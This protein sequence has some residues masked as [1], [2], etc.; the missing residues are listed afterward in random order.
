MK[1]RFFARLLPLWLLIGLTSCQVITPRTYQLE[2]IH[3]TYTK[4][5]VAAPVPRAGQSPPVGKGKGAFNATLQSI[6]NYEAQFGKGTREAAHLTVLEGMIY[7]QSGAPGMARL[8]EP[9]VA[10]AK[11]RLMSSGGVAT[12][13][14]IFAD[15]FPELV[16][17][18]SAV[19]GVNNGDR[20]V[21]ASDFRAAADGIRDKLAKITPA[22]RAAAQE[23]S[24][25]AYV[26]TS[27]AIFYIWAASGGSPPLSEM[28]RAGRDLLDPWLTPTERSSAISGSYKRS[29]MEWG[30][31]Q[32][33]V[34]WY[35]YLNA[36]SG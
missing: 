1:S 15:C 10:A 19:W 5:W 13:D 34:E 23:D 21:T 3:Q 31:R 18:W 4:E 29:D 2:Q 28:A 36:N 27:G 16:D 14:Y 20:S 22:Q 32:R 7:L 24:G 6:R 17:G 8:L 26:A 12:R 30:S 9:E 11:D 33:F 25:G 35:A